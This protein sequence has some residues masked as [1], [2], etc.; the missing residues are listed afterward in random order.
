[1]FGLA[2]NI[3]S[4][5]HL[6]RHAYFTVVIDH[7]ALVYILRSKKEPPT[8]RIKKLIKI[9]SGYN[10]KA[11]F[12]K[13]KDVHV[14]DFLSRHRGEDGS[15][16]NKII[17]ISVDIQEIEQNQIRLHEINKILNNEEELN[18]LMELVTHN[19]LVT[20][21]SKGKAPTIFPMT[22]ETKL[23]EHTQKEQTD[24]KE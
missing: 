23:P 22:R 18:T 11:Q 12:M 7:S 4:F 6:L 5:K 24:N 14:S 16:Q 2:I 13:G 15:P 19:C 21:R 20:T 8:L 9:L 10:F 17:P 3:A 1:M